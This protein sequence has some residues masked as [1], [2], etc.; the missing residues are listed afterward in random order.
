[1][2]KSALVLQRLEELRAAR[3]D[4]RYLELL[5]PDL[6]GIL[7]G[8][9][10]ASSE[11][12][13]VCEKGVFLPGGTTLLAA[14][15]QTLPGMHYG[16]Q[17]GDPDVNCRVVPHS[18]APIN[19]SSEPTL[20]ALLSL[21]E[22]DGSPY[23]ADSRYVLRRVVEH[24]AAQGISVVIA[25]ELE[26]YLLDPDP[27]CAPAPRPV[28]IAGTNLQSEGLQFAIVE[29]LYDIDHF[30]SDIMSECEAQAVPAST[31][32]AEFSP[33]QYEVNLHHGADPVLAC[34]HAILLRRI[35]KQTARKHGMA[36]TFMAKP[37][38][39][40]SGSG[41]HFH[42]SLLNSDGDNLFA[43]D[44]TEDRYSEK[45]LHAVGGVGQLLAESMA[46]FAP[47]ANSYRRYRP[48]AYVPMA[49][50]WGLNHRDVAFRLPVADA[51]NTRIEHRVAGADANPYLAAAC[52]LAGMAHGMQIK[53]DPGTPV[54]PGQIMKQQRI[55]IPCRWDD[56]IA[57]FAASTVLP[58]YLGKRFCEVYALFKR[59]ESDVYHAQIS[60]RDFAWY[61]K[62][63]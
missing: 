25:P 1:M 26:F 19:W 47:H 57:R 56:A 36:A 8:K 42:I 13:S 7:R 32:V 62:S 18:L 45:L 50:T 55:E 60:D 12:E 23:F 63:I 29:D 59:C 14:L 48:D 39:E 30:L 4:T 61:L 5:L 16:A 22:L 2:S 53:A 10:V 51:P 33:S 9:R 35:V 40:Y 11:A 3:P 6:N 58:D 21:H 44:R 38:A 37:F 54:E 41:L 46:I 24:L 31:A 28:S 27:A 52:I 34:D 17:D 15:G 43:P 20:Q 49:P